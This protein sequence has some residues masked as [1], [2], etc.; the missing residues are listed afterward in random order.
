MYN[1]KGTVK[2]TNTLPPKSYLL[3]QIGCFS[4][5]SKQQP[6]MKA[7]FNAFNLITLRM[8]FKFKEDCSTAS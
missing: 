1:Y 8:P 2:L 5:S 7:E 3:Q 4:S 6:V